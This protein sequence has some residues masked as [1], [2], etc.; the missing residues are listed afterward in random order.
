MGLNSL[1]FTMLILIL[2]SDINEC[3]SQPCEH[4][5]QC[6]DGVNS[7]KCHCE[8]GYT[9]VRCETGKISSQLR[10]CDIH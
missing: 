4:D 1:C 3:A 10:A 7:F 5:G 2:F 8:A 9:G 6:E